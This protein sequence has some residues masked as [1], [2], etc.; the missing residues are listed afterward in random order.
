MIE[1]A[2][3]A[4]PVEDRGQIFSSD[5]QSAELTNVR[6]ALAAH[7]H[8]GKRGDVYYT[9]PSRTKIDENKAAATYKNLREQFADIR[10]QH[11]KP[12]SS[13]LQGPS[14]TPTPGRKR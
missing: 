12:D 5:K 8:F 1:T 14:D 4:V 11:Q 9:D 13:E 7:R 3:A 2:L 6:A 10:K